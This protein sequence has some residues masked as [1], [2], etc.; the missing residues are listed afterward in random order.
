MIVD[1]VMGFYQTRVSVL[2][3]EIT[4]CILTYSSSMSSK[5]S[6]VQSRRIWQPPAP[7]Y[8]TG[9]RAAKSILFPCVSH[10][11]E[12]LHRWCWPKH[13]TFAE[14]YAR[15]VLYPR[16]RLADGMGDVELTSPSA[17]IERNCFFLCPMAEL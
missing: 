2:A 12:T 5:A 8:Q 1:K 11:V 15:C 13:R 10:V 7:L 14:S 4:V 17:G 6:V 16:A 3:N 9:G